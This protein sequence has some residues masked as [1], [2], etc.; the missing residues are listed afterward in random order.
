MESGIRERAMTALESLSNGR[1]LR[2]MEFIGALESEHGAQ[3]TAQECAER[4]RFKSMR[5]E[6]LDLLLTSS[7]ARFTNV[8]T[9]I[10][11]HTPK[12]EG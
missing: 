5:A 2:V 7:E 3:L 11:R 8:A 1:L 9:A 6:V 4:E 12:G 10:D